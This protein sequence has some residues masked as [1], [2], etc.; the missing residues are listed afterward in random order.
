MLELAVEIAALILL[1]H[2]LVHPAALGR[3][4][5]G[6][7]AVDLC[8]FGRFLHSVIEASEL[9]DEFDLQ[10]IGSEPHTALG[11]RVHLLRLHATAF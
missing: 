8:Q 4:S 3:I 1:R 9:V 7:I 2:E 5:L 10:R 11:D 6:V